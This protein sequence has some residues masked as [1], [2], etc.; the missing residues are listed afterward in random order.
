M[1]F[2]TGWS[3]RCLLT[4]DKTYVSA[5][6][7]T[8][9]PV[10]VSYRAS[11]SATNLPD[12]MI[13]TGHAN[14]AQADGGDIRFTSDTAGSITLP[15]EISC[16]SQNATVANAQAEIWVK[17]PTLS[18]SA[19]T[20]FYVWY[21]GGGS[22][23]QPATNSVSGSYKVWDSNYL[24][25][26][27]MN[28]RTGSSFD[29]T[30][31]QIFLTGSGDVKAISGGKF[32]SG[33]TYDATGDIYSASGWI[34]PNDAMTMQVWIK[35]DQNTRAVLCWKEGGIQDRQMRVGSPATT[36]FY[37]NRAGAVFANGT[38]VFDLVNWYS[39]AGV[40][41]TTLGSRVYVNGDV[42]DTNINGTVG[43]YQSY[44]SAVQFFVGYNG[45]DLD[46]SGLM[47]EIRISNNTRSNTWLKT[48]YNNQQRPDVFI[49]TGTPAATVD[50]SITQRIL[51][52]NATLRNCR[53]GV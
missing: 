49:I 5:S 12:E 47:D 41:D 13:Q 48:E 4:I 11:G 16:W 28:Q 51:L 17:I 2:P 46:Y 23:T 35:P 27:H 45:G 50:T 15:C 52:Q 18:T 6:N 29:S 22:E 42:E 44:T 33:S 32:G 3:R 38:T 31:N 7:Q 25:V 26:W 24:G 43:G 8:D 14:A 53:I 37:T 30:A 9:F 1:A 10:L 40:V 34:P 36:Y 20:D 19:N 21:K 39:I